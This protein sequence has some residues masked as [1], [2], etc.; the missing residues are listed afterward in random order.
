MLQPDR[1]PYRNVLHAGS[2]SQ[3]RCD[4]CGFL[5]LRRAIPRVTNSR[6]PNFRVFL[7]VRRV[8]FFPRSTAKLT[9]CAPTRRGAANV[10]L[11]P[12][13]VRNAWQCTMGGMGRRR[14]SVMYPWPEFEGDVCCQS[15]HIATPRGSCG[16]RRPYPRRHGPRIDQ[17]RS[18]FEV[19]P[20]G[21]QRPSWATS[22]VL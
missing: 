15:V 1:C 20:L 13:R 7:F 2:S 21:H 9:P 22:V 12:P 3:S 17:R 19:R 6:Q 5:P 18:A 14:G 4:S 16:A 10:R 11:L 8:R